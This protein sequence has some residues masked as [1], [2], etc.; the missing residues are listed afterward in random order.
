MHRG[1]EYISARRYQSSLFSSRLGSKGAVGWRHVRSRSRERRRIAGTKSVQTWS[2]RGHAF[3]RQ[4]LEATGDSSQIF[5]ISASQPKGFFTRPKPRASGVCPRVVRC[6]EMHCAAMKPFAQHS[7]IA[8][9]RQ[10]TLP[11]SRRSGLCPCVISLTNNC[12]VSEKVGRH[13]RLNPA[14][15]ANDARPPHQP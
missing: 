2:R 7:W 1:D 15:S 13:R 8:L 5:K 11:A 12:S 3:T 10:T 4:S 6:L 9:W 14:R